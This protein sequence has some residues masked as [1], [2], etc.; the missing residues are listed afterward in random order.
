M[1]R[2][3]DHYDENKNILFCPTRTVQ[4]FFSRV[5]LLGEEDDEEEDEDDEGVVE[6]F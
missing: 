6:L 1:M 4:Y 3:S 5:D 2:I